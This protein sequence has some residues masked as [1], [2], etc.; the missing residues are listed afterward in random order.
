MYELYQAGLAAVD[1]RRV[2]RDVLLETEPRDY[3]HVI[4][5]G[6][7]APAMALGTR[8]VYGPGASPLII[9]PPGACRR[10]PP[11]W[12]SACWEGGHPLPTRASLEAGQALLRVLESAVADADFLFLISGGASAL[13]EVPA[14]G[15]DLEFLERAN[16]WLLGSGID[17]EQVNRV[18]KRLSRIKGGQLRHWLGRRQ[19]EALMISD[20]AG[21]DPA[22]IGSGLLAATPG[23]PP[24]VELPAW[25]E[26]RLWSEAPEPPPGLLSARV[27]ASLEDA[28]LGVARAAEA[29]GL[30]TYWHEERLAAD[31]LETGRSIG[32]ALRHG[33]PGLYLYG[34]E[35]T[36]TLPARRGR[37]G[38]CQALALAAAEEIAGSEGIWLLAA[39]TDGQDGPDGDAGALVDGGTCARGATDYG[40]NTATALARADAG[41]FLAC[42]GDLI[43]T[44]S[45]GT[46]VNDLVLG[47][48]MDPSGT[49]E[50]RKTVL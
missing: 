5:I 10:V 1:G 4:A 25:L 7:A 6:K 15:V 3:R 26:Q 50:G 31:A 21:D 14:P 38:R 30:E 19:S 13:V 43:S 34:G 12:R 2:V 44:G 20:V 49:P 17:I 18:R 33:P 45:T 32:Q 27:I 16:H 8:D 42:A 29:R 37:G 36:V 48:K 23:P 11:E 39:G 47:L 40:A 22:V 35:T 46:N 28:M 9:G 24:A 41:T